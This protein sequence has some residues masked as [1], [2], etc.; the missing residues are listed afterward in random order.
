MVNTAL[1]GLRFKSDTI[2]DSFLQLTA[3]DS[4]PILE[5]GGPSA[6]KISEAIAMAVHVRGLNIPEDLDREISRESQDRATTWSDAATELLEEAVRMRRAPGV[7]F[8]DGPAGRRAVV[9]GTGLDVW[10]IVASWK[11]SAQD[12]HL[13]RQ[14]YTWLSEPQLRSA[15]A[16]YEAY[17][18]EVDARLER[19]AQWTAEKVAT[20]LPFAAPRRK[21]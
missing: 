4:L 15:L 8:A 5:T 21:R 17:P 2:P 9:A 6:S 12:F 18:H 16:Y 1:L 7:V 11:A 13:L 14:S 19:E 20:E 10:E 3:E